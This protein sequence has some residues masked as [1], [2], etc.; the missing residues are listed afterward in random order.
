MKIGVLADTHNHRPNTL[1]ALEVFRAEGVEYLVHCGDVTGPD[2]VRLLAEWPVALVTGNV[3]RDW[4]ALADAARAIGVPPPR[5]QV[6]LT[7]DGLAIAVVHGHLDEALQDLIE[8]QEYRYIFHG[9]THLR[10]DVLIGRTRVINP[11]ALG[12][13]RREPRSV[14]VVDLAANEVRFVEIPE[15]Q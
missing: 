9:H 4:Q 7:L 1:A 12:G 13:T 6:S 14:A 2:I 5:P 8:R 11:G 10:R 3:D 15:A